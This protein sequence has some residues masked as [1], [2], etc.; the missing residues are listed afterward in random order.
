[1]VFIKRLLNSFVFWGA[2]IIIPLLV[3]I[4]PAIGCFFLLVKRRIL[5]KKNQGKEEL[6]F[7]PEISIIIPVYNSRDTLFACVKSVYDSTYPTDKI[8]IFLVNNKGQDDSFRVYA[9]CQEMFPDLMMQWLNAEQGKSRAL[10]LALYNSEGKYIINIDSDGV[11]EKNALKNLITKFE[12]NPKLNCM[13]GSILTQPSLIEQYDKKR[14]R[15]LR[16]LEFMEYAQAFLAGRSYASE[17]N[18]VYTLSGAFSAFRKSA[19]L[20]SRLYNTDTIC[21]DTQ[22]TF[23]MRY[24]Y[25][26]RVEICED[27]IF[28]VE[29]IEDMDK[30]YTQRQR[31][32]RGSLEVAKMFYDKNFKLTNAFK[33]VNIRTLLFDHTFAF[34]R[35]IWYMAL[36]CL[37]GMNYSTKAIYFSTGLLFLLYILVGYLYFF[38]SYFL[39][40]CNPEIQKY[41]G[42]QWK[43]VI[44][45]PFFNFMVF[46]IRMAGIINS[47]NTDSSWKSRTFTEE[48]KAFIKTLSHDLGKFTKIRVQI[49]KVLNKNYQKRE[50]ETS[51]QKSIFWFICVGVIYFVAITIIIVGT[52]I[53]KDLN[54]GL[55]ELITTLKGPV[56]GTGTGMI[57]G[58]VK[59]CVI[60][61]LLFMIIWLIISLITVQGEKKGHKKIWNCVQHG[62]EK[63][64]IVT[65]VCAILLFNSQYQALAYI[66]AKGA[67]TTI[68]EEYY[69]TPEIDKITAN[70]KTKNLIYIFLESMETTYASEK[71]GGAQP[72]Y[73]YIP[74]LTELSKDNLSFGD[75]EKMRGWHAIYGTT[76]TMAALFAATSGLPFCLPIS[77]TQLQQ[78][79]K[80]ASGVTNLGDVLTQKGYHQEFLCGSDSSFGGKKMYFE[81]HGNYEIFDYFTAKE[82]GLVPK[83][84]HVNW[85]IEDRKI[86]DYAK[87]EIIQLAK[88]DAPFN[89]T[90]LTVDTHA[91]G[92]FICEECE[93]KYEVDTANVVDCADRHVAEFVNWCKEQDFYEDTIIVITGD[94]PRMDTYLVKDTNY[95]DRTV[96]NCFLNVDFEPMQDHTNRIITAMDMFPSVLSAMGFSI[97]GDKLGLGTNLFSNKKTIAE[98]YGYEKLDGELRKQSDYYIDV[99]APEAK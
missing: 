48:K 58:I 70:G 57:G 38:A 89:F 22:V 90:M 44:I 1:M 17:T 27:A 85:G 47:I 76:W 59:H 56:E 71:D 61:V 86:F 83:D 12:K 13:T 65:L 43:Y 40:R 18:S 52:W 94:H 5:M 21:E 91:P 2:W 97:E 77:D 14:A 9:K 25:K 8:R 28:F 93:D 30:L 41:Y 96:Y 98:E 81:Q 74:N 75:G 80:F 69:V 79:G 51:E 46:F 42:K 29:P 33:D 50:K 16:R 63:I 99:F 15:I 36:L 6:T 88:E 49:K 19:I 32:Q 87:D 60:P 45:L 53:R 73:N 62:I 4:I 31:W 10:N 95:Y 26:E 72:H 54:V 7:F 11:L 34:P 84:Y 68:F 37:I 67:E 82:K 39:L 35:L 3:E 92:G 78:T 66:K 55:S 24:I 64:G 23:Q 20:N